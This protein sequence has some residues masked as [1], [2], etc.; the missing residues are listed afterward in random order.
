MSLIGDTLTFW[1]N[2]D[3]ILEC[4]Q[5]IYLKATSK[6]VGAIPVRQNITVLP[7]DNPRELRLGWVIHEEIG[8]VVINDQALS[9]VNLSFSNYP[10]FI[11]RCEDDWGGPH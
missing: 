9:T 6:F 2:Y 5:S 7:A 10:T 8:M 11:R 4:E 1:G 3:K